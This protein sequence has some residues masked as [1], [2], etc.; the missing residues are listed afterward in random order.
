MGP[1]IL[2]I[3]SEEK[4]TLVSKHFEDIWNEAE[5]LTDRFVEKDL[6]VIVDE[7]K[8][9][10]DKICS[11]K[12]DSLQQAINIGEILFDLAWIVKISEKESNSCI[13]VAGAMNR[14]IVLREES[15]K[16]IGKMK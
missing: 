8:Y 12:N 5:I 13:N 14:A 15:Y 3:M 1:D 2:P 7:I 4:K 10:L 16:A 11:L 9:R 6:S